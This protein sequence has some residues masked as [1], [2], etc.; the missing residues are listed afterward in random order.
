[1]A[2]SVVVE[3]ECSTILI[4]EPITGFQMEDITN[5]YQTFDGNNYLRRSR[6]K[7]ENNIKVNLKEV[8]SVLLLLI[9]FQRLL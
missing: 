7:W 5:A 1:M 3:N 2:Y 8:S 9:R 4:P 6:P